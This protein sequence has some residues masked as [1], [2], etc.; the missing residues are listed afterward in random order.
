MAVVEEKQIIKQYQP[1]IR[2]LVPYEQ[3][4][5]L[6]EG[7][8]KFSTRLPSNIRRIVKDEV[9]RLTSLT[10]APADNSAFALFPVMKFKHFG[11]QMRLDKVGA[12]ILKDETA[13]YQNRYTVGVFESVMNSEYYQTQV[14]KEQFRKIVDAFN[15]ESQSFSDI[16]FGDNVAVSPNFTVSSL[17]F[18]KGKSSAISSLGFRNMTV[19]S[20][21]PPTVSNGQTLTFTFP[22]I[23]GFT[24]EPTDITYVLNAVKYNKHSGKYESHFV[25]A[26]DTDPKLAHAIENYVTSSIYQ[27]PLQRDLEV[28]RAMQ[29]LERDR[30]LENSPWLPVY[31]RQ[32]KNIFSAVT[33]LV[34]KANAQFNTVNEVLN[35][36]SAGMQSG[37]LYQELQTYREAFV[38]SGVVETRKGPVNILTTHRQLVA[39]G[40]LAAYIYLLNKTASLSCLHCRLAEVSNDDKN[41]AYAIH[42]I[43]PKVLPDVDTLSHVLF[44]REVRSQLSKLTLGEKSE[45]KPIPKHWVVSETGKSIGYVM[46]EALDRRSETRYLV[47]KPASVKLGLLSSLNARLCDVSCKGMRLTVAPGIHKF[48]PT[49]KVTIPEFKLKNGVYSVLDYHPESGVLRLCV[50]DEVRQA[51]SGAQIN[52]VV[53]ENSAYFKLRDVAR[54]QRFLHRFLWELAVRHLPSLSVLCVMNRHWRDRMK[55]VYQSES[56][57]DLYPFSKTQNI[58][59]LHGFFADKNAAK[60]KSQLLDALFSGKRDHAMVV[61]CLRKSDDKLVFIRER[62]YFQSPLRQQIQKKLSDEQIQLCTSEIIAVRCHDTATPLTKKRLAQLS[63]L[64]KAMYDKLTTMQDGYTHCIYITN[65]SALENDIVRANLRTPRRKA[66]TP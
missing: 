21:R 58:T 28:E 2:A 47:D 16:D 23:N 38:I 25:L 9:I 56:S 41:K 44:C 43:S 27:Q 24:Q 52:A 20:R 45:F 42:D 33:A 63:K 6:L 65:I 22:E 39:E 64:D 59:P 55:T 30:L 7:I 5:R 17:D 40:Q 51:K 1:L 57:D 26:E 13:L 50:Q 54:Q 60:P 10:D 29:D 18:E 4:N 37:H 34:T 12:Q 8:N 32:N 14:K 53:E 3:Q 19:E 36:L 31:L 48:N 66:P 46:E 62:D 49:V 11:V 35:T 15:I 61:H